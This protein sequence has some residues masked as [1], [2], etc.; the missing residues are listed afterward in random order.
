MLSL[1]EVKTGTI[2]RLDNKPFEVQ[3]VEHSKL[4]RGGAILRTKIKN[5]LDG[6][7]VDKTFKGSEKLE[8]IQLK[9]KKYQYSYAETD[10][11]FFMDPDNF[12]QVTISKSQIDEKHKYLKEGTS[13]E[14][15][16]YERNSIAINLPIKMIFEITYTEPGL[17]GD[18]KSST[19]L[20]PAK[21]DTGF[22]IKVPLFIKTGDKIVVDTRDGRYVQKVNN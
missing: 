4:G 16:F 14:I 11:Y 13:V 21:I 6:T 8:P 12:E 7:T 9:R 19:A 2:I 3:W 22:E 15:L 20:K 17:K 1:N 5:L 18:T 10:N